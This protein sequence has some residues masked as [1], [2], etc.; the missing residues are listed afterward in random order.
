M[1]RFI[2][3]EDDSGDEHIIE[4]PEDNNGLYIDIPSRPLKIIRVL[5]YL[6][7]AAVGGMV[8]SCVWKVWG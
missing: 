1:K 6:G 7:V 2:T 5:L 4:L 3:L 8:F